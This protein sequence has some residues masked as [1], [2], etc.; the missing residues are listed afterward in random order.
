MTRRDRSAL[1]LIVLGL[2]YSGLIYLPWVNKQEPINQ[3]IMA[4][5]ALLIGAGVGLFRGEVK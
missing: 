5:S 4:N 2:A 1:L 3:F